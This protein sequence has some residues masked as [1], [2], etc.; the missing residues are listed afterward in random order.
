MNVRKTFLVLGFTVAC[1]ASSGLAAP[2]ELPGERLQRIIRPQPVAP[3][4]VTAAPAVAP[5]ANRAGPKIQFADPVYDFGRS[6]ANIPVKHTYVFTNVGDETLTLTSVQPLCGCTMAGEFTHEVPPGKTG[7]VPVQF[8]GVGSGVVHKTVNVNSNDKE[9]PLVALQITGTLWTPIT[10]EPP[11]AALNVSPDSTA[12]TNTIRIVNNTEE[13]LTLSEPESNQRGIAATLTTTKPGKEFALTV[14]TLEPWATAGLAG[15]ITIRTSSTNVPPIVITA[16]VNVQQAVTY[17]PPVLNLP[18]GPL[19]NQQM[20]PIT[21]MNHSTNTLTLSE[22]VVSA[23]DVVVQLV[24]P[25]P[26]KTFTAT[27]SFPAGFTLPPNQPAEFTV[28]SSNP[29]FPL[30]RVP[31]LQAQMPR[32]NN[33]PQAR[34]LPL[35][36]RV[37]PPPAPIQPPAAPGAAAGPPPPPGPASQ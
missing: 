7:T 26:G 16:W 20:T 21:I 5:E 6:P 15:Q 36:P 28:K 32:P 18:A 23:K 25:Q 24:E 3:A 30:I 35:S 9:H 13:M 19:P 12:A 22:P 17:Y 31:I 8:N 11:N 1:M 37:L 29:K 33:V 10:L 14:R 27:L 2:P 34:P 4:T